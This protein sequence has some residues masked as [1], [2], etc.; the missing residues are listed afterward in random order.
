MGS[1]PVGL[2][3]SRGAA[4]LGL[5]KYQTSFGIWQTIME[6]KKPGFNKKHGYVYEPFEGN[7]FTRWG[8]AFEDSIIELAE[9]KQRSEI[10]LREAHYCVNNNHFVNQLIKK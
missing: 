2:S 3:A 7:V 4:I 1:K 8:T 6:Q 9:E 5:S 10:G